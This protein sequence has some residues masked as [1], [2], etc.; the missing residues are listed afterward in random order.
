MERFTE[1]RETGRLVSGVDSGENQIGCFAL[2]VGIA[3]RELYV[4][5][6]CPGEVCGSAIGNCFFGTGCLEPG[7]IVEGNGTSGSGIRGKRDG[8][9]EC[10]VGSCGG[11]CSPGSESGYAG[12]ESVVERVGRGEV[13]RDERGM[14]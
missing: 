5:Y 14:P 3:G 8:A 12:R 7:R 1:R 11:S 2:S 9:S 4:E 10:R 6:L 13:C